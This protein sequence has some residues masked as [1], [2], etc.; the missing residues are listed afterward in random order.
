[1]ATKVRSYTDKELLDRVKS[2]NNFKLI[3]YGYWI[4]GVRSNEDTS[5]VYDD[6]FYLFFGEKFICVTT[7]TT[8]PG[9]PIL[10]GGY[11][12]YN[13]DGAFVLKSDWWHYNMWTPGYHNGKMKALRQVSNVFGFRDGN[14][15]DKSEEV[16]KEVVGMFGIN[17]HANTYNALDRVVKWFIG[18]WSAG[19]QVCNNRAEYNHIIEL[20]GSQKYVSYCL[21]KEF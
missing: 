9:T 15:N 12:S 8:N 11:L 6:K 5:N 10:K 16:G 21:I 7:G 2:L 4:L 18:G 20:I 1:M 14:K 19:C 17:F 13:K 3:P